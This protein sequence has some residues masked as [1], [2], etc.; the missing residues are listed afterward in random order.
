MLQNT[1]NAYFEA[2]LVNPKSIDFRD[3]CLA[4]ADEIYAYACTLKD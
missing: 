4:L 1:F 3:N 2:N